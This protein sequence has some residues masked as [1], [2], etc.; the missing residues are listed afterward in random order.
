[1]RKT[2]VAL[3]GIFSLSTY[4]QESPFPKFGKVTAEH[5]Q[6]KVYAI[7]SA[8]DAVVLSD[9]GEA[10]IEGNSKGG[11]SVMT[12]RHKVVHV[13]TKNGYDEATVEIYLYTSG[14]AEEKLEDL[15]AVTYNLEGGKVVTSKFERSNLFTEK[16]DKNHIVKK[17][18]LP[19]VKE[20]SIIE[21]QYQVSSDFI[22][23]VDPW[24]FQGRAPRLWSEFRFI[25]PQFF[26]YT[27]VSHGY[28]RPFISDKK[29]RTQQFTVRDQGGTT[30]TETYNFSSGVTEYRWAMKDVP[31][32]KVE[33]FT[34]TLKNHLA[35]IEFQLVS[36]NYPLTPHNFRNSW[37]SLTKELLESEDFGGNIKGSNG[38]L[39]DDMKTILAGATT[40][41]EKAKRIYNFVREAFT[42]TNYYRVFSEQSIKST[43]KNKKGSVSEINLLLT[44]MLRF[45]G[46]KA[47]PVIMSQSDRGY[48]Y[49]IYPLITQF[50]YVIALAQID[51]KDVCLDGTHTGLG[52][53]RLLPDCYNGH[54]RV[55]NEEASPIYLMADSIQERKVTAL[56]LNV[57][58]KGVW[59]GN[60]NQSPGYYE[61][62][63][64]RQKIKEKGKEEFFK[65]VQKEYGADFKII[66]PRIDS[67]SNYDDPISMAYEVTYNPEKENIM[68]INPMFGEGYK[69]NPFK[70]AERMY[71]VE[72]PYAIDET[73][74]LTLQ[75]P[76]GYVVDEMP[77]QVLAKYDEVGKSYFEYRIQQSGNT[78]SMRSRIKLTRAF[79]EP[80]EYP[81]L[82]EFFN[83]VVKKHNEQIVL[84]K[85]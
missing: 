68:Y 8:A 58:E 41:T 2:L 62:Y 27:F 3:F 66:N 12:T 14:T 44:A 64:L 23:N 75:V 65:D 43:F 30:A 18:T 29:D 13:L 45:A 20:G 72:M 74:I 77:K 16:K 54:A 78:I 22:S 32:L 55:V 1:M 81:V 19:N 6:T 40:E 76:D 28:L 85:K 42:C 70:S 26:S 47:D 63:R 51:G 83:M 57:D 17:F 52:F 48:V 21:F 25:V 37:P 9:V 34:S 35:Q 82:R 84:K 59:A 49:D 79:Y 50:N 73:Y 53:G 5:L 38:W 80:D 69:K 31:E 10:A 60:M 4:A 11:F 71:P 61:S 36:R 15:K 46:I 56:F 7:D 33:S 24:A 39:A 67:I